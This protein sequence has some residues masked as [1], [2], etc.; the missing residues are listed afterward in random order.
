MLPT[1]ETAA[2]PADAVEVGRIA[3]AWGIKGWFKVLPHSARPE[4]LFSSK[5][6]FIQPSGPVHAAPRTQAFRLAIREAKEHSDCIVATSD[7]VPDRNAAEALRG[8]RV[9]VP[10]SSFP[11]AGEDEYY[12]VDLIGL[13]VVN[14][15]GVA[16]GT[17][18]E[19][20]A[21][22]PQTTLVLTADAPAGEAGAAARTIE[23]MVPFVSAFVDEVD[24]AGRTIKVDWQP[25]Y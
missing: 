17:V 21:T 15:E 24:L 3:D 25:D 8:A 23:R 16:L 10:R 5:R 12:W 9:F 6:W 1:L 13:D 7:D 19:L 20:L 18:R 2:L 4:A 14:R 11:T 22:G